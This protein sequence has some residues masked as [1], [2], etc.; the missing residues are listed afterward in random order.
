VQRLFC[1]CGIARL[2]A[3]APV[4][5]HQRKSSGESLTICS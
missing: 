2:L 1:G 3:L 5:I 4:F